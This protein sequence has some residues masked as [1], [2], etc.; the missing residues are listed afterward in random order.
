[1][2]VKTPIYYK[3]SGSLKTVDEQSTTPGR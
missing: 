2:T 3:A 1:M